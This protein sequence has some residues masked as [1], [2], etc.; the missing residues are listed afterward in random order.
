M[1]DQENRRIRDHDIPDAATLNDAVHMST[2][3]PEEIRKQKG[4]KY[5]LVL[6]SPANIKRCTLL[7][8]TETIR[9]ALR[10][11]SVLEYPDIMISTQE[12]PDGWE[13][14][15][16]KIVEIKERE[17][18]KPGNRGG[19]KRKRQH[20]KG[21]AL[22]Q[23]VAQHPT[24]TEEEAGAMEQNKANSEARP[25]EAESFPPQPQ[26]D[27]KPSSVGIEVLEGASEVPPEPPAKKSR[28]E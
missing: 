27:E 11:Q 10:M 21:M 16:K 20:N 4:L 6:Q 13:L 18:K 28:T 5:F 24:T 26:D 12:N 23:D 25:S 2:V 15:S 3:L 22:I 8:K 17:E 7:E 9:E 1:V 19:N 14:I